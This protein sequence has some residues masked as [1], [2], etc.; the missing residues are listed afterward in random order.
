MTTANPYLVG[1][2]AKHPRSG[3]VTDHVISVDAYSLQDACQQAFV[4]LEARHAYLEQSYEMKVL[5]V[6]PATF[7]MRGRLQALL[8]D[9]RLARMAT[10]GAIA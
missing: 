8:A 9:L 4:E 2:S 3:V 5:W 7:V 1:L 6:S 10:R